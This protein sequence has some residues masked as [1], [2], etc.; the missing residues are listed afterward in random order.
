MKRQR[1]DDLAGARKDDPAENTA[2]VAPLR[3]MQSRSDC[4]G[5][6]RA[7]SY[8][9]FIAGKDIP[10]TIERARAQLVARCEQ[11]ELDAERYH[12]R[13]FASWFDYQRQCVGPDKRPKTQ[14]AFNATYDQS[15]DFI[16]ANMGNA[17]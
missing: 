6:I 14:E 2:T 8:I 10:E 5:C 12:A 4:E 9:T 11:A 1:I 15:S 17:K 7:A 16:A 3:L 13:R